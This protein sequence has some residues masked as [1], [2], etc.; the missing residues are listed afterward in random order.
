M[1]RNRLS[2]DYDRMI[3]PHLVGEDKEPTFVGA[4][5]QFD[6]DLLR[7]EWESYNL[8]L[9]CI[10][11]GAVIGCTLSGERNH[12]LIPWIEM[13]KR[14]IP[15]FL[16][17]HHN[18]VASF[19]T[20]CYLLYD[21]KHR[22][23]KTAWVREAGLQER[24][25]PSTMRGRYNKAY[26]L[27]VEYTMTARRRAVDLLDEQSATHITIETRAMGGNDLKLDEI[28]TN[29]DT[30][31]LRQHGKIVITRWRFDQSDTIGELPL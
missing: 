25:S 17:T 16:R 30:S 18:V 5:L 26:E 2:T 12:F 7:E 14:G 29:I 15:K 23:L 21:S 11:A 4:E 13:K 28:I 1:N 27:L 9:M 8:P 31:E 3:V 6:L 19:C 10:G 24:K 22:R 20:N